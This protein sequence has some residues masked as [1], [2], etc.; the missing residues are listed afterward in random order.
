MQNSPSSGKWVNSGIYSINGM[1][2]SN[3]KSN[4]TRNK[5]NNMDESQ[6]HSAERKKPDVRGYILY[7]SIYVLPQKR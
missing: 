4:G 6:M 5:R 2:L 7:D 3:I 1:L